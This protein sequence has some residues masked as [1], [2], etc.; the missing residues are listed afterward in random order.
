MSYLGNYGDYCKM[1]IMGL[2]LLAKGAFL[3]KAI[4]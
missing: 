4:Y 3:R 2:Q 1:V